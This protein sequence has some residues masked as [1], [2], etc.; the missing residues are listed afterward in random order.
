MTSSGRFLV[1]EHWLCQ[2]LRFLGM[3]LMM[4]GNIFINIGAGLIDTVGVAPPFAASMRSHPYLEVSI[5]KEVIGP[6]SPLPYILSFAGVVGALEKNCVA[7]LYIVMVS[8]LDEIEG[9]RQWG[10][11]TI[12]WDDPSPIFIGG[13]RPR[14][15]VDVAATRDGRVMAKS[16]LS[17]FSIGQ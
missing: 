1:L 13:T 2:L 8:M 17:G 11:G 16:R 9:F 15:L 4:S 10:C 6:V 5:S 12:H 3:N 14:L 7:G